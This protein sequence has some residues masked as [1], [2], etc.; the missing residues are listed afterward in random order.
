MFAFHSI[1]T[2][3]KPDV[4]KNIIVSQLNSN[5]RSLKLNIKRFGEKHQ[6]FAAPKCVLTNSTE[7]KFAEFSLK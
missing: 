7:T 5:Q 6:I 3:F 1:E 2:A 4:Q